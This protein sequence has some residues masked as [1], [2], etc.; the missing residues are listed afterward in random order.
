MQ[1]LEKPKYNVD[2]IINDAK[3]KEGKD[4][5]NYIA[6]IMKESQKELIE[7]LYK[8]LGKDFLL[9]FFEKA[10]TIENNTGM[11]RKIPRKKKELEENEKTNNEQ[12]ILK[13]TIGGIFFFL[14]RNNE[15]Q[16]LFVKTIFKNHA[17]KTQKVK[18]LAKKFEKID[19]GL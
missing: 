2:S 1:Q 10:L 16:N 9:K 7:D 3:D 5:T 14:I 6:F 12:A 19:F 8:E 17:K 18:K 11:E 15:K 4:F 13:R